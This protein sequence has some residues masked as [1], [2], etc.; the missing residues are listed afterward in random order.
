MAGRK[1]KH[2]KINLVYKL[3]INKFIK[4]YDTDYTSGPEPRSGH[5][6]VCNERAMYAVGGYNPAYYLNRSVNY[7]VNDEILFHELWR[8]DFCSKSWTKLET[9]NMPL[10]LASFATVLCGNLLFLYGGTGLPFGT[11]I[12]EDV[13]TCKLHFAE[14][15]FIFNKVPIEND[16]KKPLKQYG[17]SIAIVGSYLYTVGG[18]D[19]FSYSMDVYRLNIKTRTW[20]KLSDQLS[21]FCNPMPRYRHEIIHYNNYLYVL[22][23]G[24][25]RA[26]FTLKV[27]YIF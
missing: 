2:S 7:I 16:M 22:G 27:S 18:T 5:R 15:K 10:E 13:Y 21:N 23:G 20:E 11:E 24:S 19:G 3:Q 17:Q 8:F 6:I 4:V 9:E 12:N 14:T 25:S 26:S 1:R